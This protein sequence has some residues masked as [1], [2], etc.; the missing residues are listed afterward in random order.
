MI[1]KDS[2][3][4]VAVTVLVTIAA[5]TAISEMRKSEVR[6][7]ALERLGRE[8]ALQKD[9]KSRVALLIETNTILG[10]NQS[11]FG[12]SN[13]SAME[14]GEPL[15]EGEV[16]WSKWWVSGGDSSSVTTSETWH[17]P[18]TDYSGGN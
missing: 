8:F 17:I 9:S 10:Q 12:F 15:L 13:S 2:I 16:D 7:Q 6:Q 5:M 14:E 1:K 4:L 11:L 18:G 3:V